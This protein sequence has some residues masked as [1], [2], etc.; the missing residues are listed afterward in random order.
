[1][2][3]TKSV[4][5]NLI[6]FIQALLVFLLFFENGVSLPSWLQV[7]GRL[8]PA[9]LHMPIGLL[10]FLVIILFARNEF[11]QKAFR[12]IVLVILLFTAFSASVTALFGFFLS[13]QGDY[14]A[15]V[16]SRHK[17]AGVIL[18]LICYGVLIIFDRSKKTGTTFYGMVVLMMG[19]MLFAGHTGGTITHG[20]N[21]VLGPL[22][23]TAAEKAL[24]EQASVFDRAV[25]PILERKCV[26]CH[27]KTKAKGK[28]VMTSHED[29]IKGGKKG[30]EWVEG[31]PLESRMIQ[32][33][34][35]PLEDDDHMPP[36]GKV[37][38]SPRE[39]KLLENW[40]KN[41]GSF[42]VK[43]AEL[44]D[45]DSLKILSTALLSVKATVT[46][47]KHYP[48]SAASDEVIEKMNTPFRSVFP[49]SQKS[50]ALQA[51]FFVKEAFQLKSLEELGEVEKQLVILNLSKMPVTDNELSLI[52][53]FTNLEKLNLNFS[54]ISGTGLGSLKALSNLNSLSL[55][56]T[57]VNAESLLPVLTLPALKE[58]FIWNTKVTEDEKLDLMKRY[59]KIII[60]SSQFRD[61]KILRLGKPSLVNEGMVKK[62]GLVSI[63]HS[64]PGVIIRYTLDGTNPDSLSALVYKEPVKINSTA[65]IKAIACKPGWYCSD[66]FQVTCFLE[67]YT[68]E[69]ATLLSETDSYYRGQGAKSLTDG[70]KGFIEVLNAPPWLGYKERPFIA[71]FDFGKNP[72]EIKSIVLS[73]ARNPG[74]SNFPPTEVEV[75]GG[76]NSKD[77]KLIRNMK[78]AQPTGGEPMQVEALSIPIPVSSY[79]YYKLIAKPVDKL[80]K[81]H[82]SKGKKGWLL[83]DEVIFN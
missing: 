58:L 72:P 60:A 83:V 12:K 8:H 19:S 39:I 65:K 41:G 80:P 47:E 69:L 23:A 49:L 16:V 66:R 10:V 38:L 54:K 82:N 51:D 13:Q 53:K 75:W 3:K 29:F 68:P 27:N 56:G 45:V 76:K 35:L 73:Y 52:G 79:S 42:E 57:D 30:K 1:M 6:F 25:Y 67:G 61:D 15:D 43:L 2:L 71:G 74:S 55:A 62:N 34:H 33:I 70:E 24:D 31:E 17:I 40:I 81:W 37:Q 59:P 4:F 77:I 14:D 64:M 18:S 36:D 22:A 9:V 5:F 28:L 63:K 44:K 46:A 7:A 50:P 11:K 21:Y 48:F 32:Y 26:S 78:V 20:E